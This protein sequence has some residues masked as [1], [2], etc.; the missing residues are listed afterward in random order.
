MY[1][2]MATPLQFYNTFKNR[3]C[4]AYLASKGIPVIPTVSWGNKNTFNFC[5]EGIERGATVAVS[6]YMVS[7]HNNHSDQKEFFMA[8]Y[9]EM[10]S[11]LEPKNIICY[12]TPFS[13]MEG[14]IIHVDYD[15]SSWQHLNDDSENKKS[16]NSGIIIKN[17]VAY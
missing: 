10:L 16:L 4:G 8:G 17:P 6:T 7:E 9:N 14:N 13:E 11:R 2:Q 15:L 3:W 5:F 12:N 1:T